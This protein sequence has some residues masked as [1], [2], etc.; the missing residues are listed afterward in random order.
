MYYLNLFAYGMYFLG[1]WV[2]AVLSLIFVLF[3]LHRV[4]CL[5][6]FLARRRTLPRCHYR[7]LC[8]ERPP[9]WTLPAPDGPRPAERLGLEP[10]RV[11]EE[12]KASLARKHFTDLLVP[13]DSA[14]WTPER[15]HADCA[16]CL[17]GIT[18]DDRCLLQH[19]Y[20][21]FHLK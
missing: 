18:N 20:H 19:C 13:E 12:Q 9:R 5:R 6:E 17:V 1:L 16:I 10:H 3:F 2:G 11:E 21:V 7:N 8:R 15:L 14:E 4:T